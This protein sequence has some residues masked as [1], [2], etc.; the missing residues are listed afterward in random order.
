MNHRPTTKHQHHLPIRF[1]PSQLAIGVFAA[2]IVAL[3][4]VSGAAAQADTETAD[5]H[6]EGARP[7]FHMSVGG[8]GDF[9]AGFRLD[10]PIVPSGF[11]GNGRDEFALSPGM[12]IQFVDFGHDEDDDDSD[13]LLLPQLATQWNFYFPRGWSI[14]PEVGLAVVIGDSHHDYNDGS[15]NVHV[16]GLLAFGARRHFSSRTAL[17]MRAGW[18]NGFQLGFAI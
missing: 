4:G 2:L 1:L 14:F 5:R 7:E 9:G 11:L 17:V 13:L 3:A 18:P 16:D 6:I 8:H 10:L 15:A 12:D